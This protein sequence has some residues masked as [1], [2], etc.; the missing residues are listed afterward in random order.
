MRVGHEALPVESLQPAVG[1]EQPEEAVGMAVDAAH[2]A[3]GQPI[4]GGMEP[5]GTRLR[6]RRQGGHGQE[7]G[8]P[9]FP[10]WYGGAWHRHGP[11]VTGMAIPSPPPRTR[12]PAYRTDSARAYALRTA[13]YAGFRRPAWST[14]LQLAPGQRS[15]SCHSSV[16]MQWGRAPTCASMARA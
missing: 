10:A 12:D 3:P 2:H 4:G 9:G 6:G 1:A 15:L 8:Q 11:K 16:P 5:L 13:S 7:Q 14:M